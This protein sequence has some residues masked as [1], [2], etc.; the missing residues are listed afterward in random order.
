MGLSIAKSI[1]CILS[2]A[3]E[4][5]EHTETRTLSP[6]GL[7]AERFN[8]ALA[9]LKATGLEYRPRPFRLA[10]RVGRFETSPCSALV[11]WR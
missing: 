5:I 2:D 8:R 10:F 3:I 1:G 4:S 7:A 6:I 11:Q 9:S